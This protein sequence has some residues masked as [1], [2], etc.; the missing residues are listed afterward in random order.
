MTTQD[1]RT[2]ASAPK[3]EAAKSIGWH[4]AYIEGSRPDLRVPVRQVHLTNGN[5]VTLYDTS[6]PYTDPAVE[7]DVRRGLTPLR[8]HW[9]TARGDT[10]EYAGRPV[11]PEDDGIKHTPARAGGFATSTRSSPAAPAS[12]AGPSPAARSRNSPTRGAA[13]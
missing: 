5:A 7:T 10:E 2:P 1:A 6:G 9:I 12:R 8:E 4:K 11:R 3:S 13:R